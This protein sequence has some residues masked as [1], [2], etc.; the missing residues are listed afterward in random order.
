M[1]NPSPRVPSIPSIMMDELLMDVLTL[2]LNRSHDRVSA[3]LWILVAL[4]TIKIS[5]AVARADR[6]DG[7]AFLAERVAVEDC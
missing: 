4:E 7:K 3:N 1:A 5:L 2:G 6:S